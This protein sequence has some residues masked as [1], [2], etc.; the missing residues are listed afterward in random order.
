M[1]DAQTISIAPSL[2]F[3]VLPS[4]LRHRHP[5][6]RPVELPA[7]SLALQVLADEVISLQV[8]TFLHSTDWH[9]IDGLIS[10]LIE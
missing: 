8:T 2:L 3:A 9:W 4:L 10:R 6:H 1:V 7:C 5:L